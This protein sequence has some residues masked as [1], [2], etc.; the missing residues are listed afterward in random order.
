MSRFT[1]LLLYVCIVCVYCFLSLLLLSGALRTSRFFLHN[2]VTKDFQWYF[3]MD[4]FCRNSRC[5]IFSPEPCGRRTSPASG[6][7]RATPSGAGGGGSGR[8]PSGV[9]TLIE[10]TYLKNSIAAV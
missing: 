5:V 8:S 10:D 6:R 7:G 9:S 3:P 4:C 2:C 1:H